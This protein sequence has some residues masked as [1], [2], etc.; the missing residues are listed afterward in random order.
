ML[1]N[2]FEFRMLW[3]LFVN[4]VLASAALGQAT[5]SPSISIDVNLNS[6]STVQAWEVTWRATGLETK[7]TRY[8][9]KIED[10]GE[11]SRA[12]SLFLRNLSAS[13]PIRKRA[14][15]EFRIQANRIWGL[16]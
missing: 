10:W 2:R 8:Q 14:H 16:G 7:E 1:T 15:R 11:W 9:L 6:S 5:R 12:D 13:L 3:T 4:G